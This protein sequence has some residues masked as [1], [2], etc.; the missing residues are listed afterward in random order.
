MRGG[1]CERERER[2][3]WSCNASCA[4]SVCFVEWWRI[5][6]SVDV[7]NVVVA[8]LVVIGGEERAGVVLE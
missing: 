7:F 2:D 8:V 5:G 4:E 1:D 3:G 6:V